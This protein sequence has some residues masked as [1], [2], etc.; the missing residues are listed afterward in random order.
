VYATNAEIT[1][2]IK[3]TGGGFGT[4]S[5][6]TI[7]NG[8]TIDATGIISSGTGRI[9]IG[10][11][12]FISNNATDLTISQVSNGANL[13]KTESVAGATD[14]P[15]RLLIGGSG[16]QV[17]VVQSAQI[18]GDSTVNSD[19]TSTA[20]TNAY[21]SGGLR[22]IFTSSSGNLSGSDSTIIYNYPSALTGDVL[23]VYDA[24][25]PPS[26]NFK[27]IVSMYIKTSGGAT[28]TTTTT[29]AATT[30][31]TAATTTTTAAPSV[32]YYQGNSVCNSA[33]GCYTTLPNVSGPFTASSI[34]SDTL[35][36]PSTDR[37]K[38]VYR[39]TS[40]DALADAAQAS[41]VDCATTTTTTAATTTTTAATT[42]TTA[43]T[44]TT[45][46][47]T[48]TTTAATTTTT[49]ATTTT[50]AAPCPPTSPTR[51]CTSANAAA[52]CCSGGIAGCGG[53][54]SISFD[55]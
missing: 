4:F 49:A 44:T 29:T 30:T 42:T 24:S 43:A 6:G 50:T 20:A 55:C 48:T 8:W 5:S 3:A 10:D 15:L 2:I 21:R 18:S 54:G 31:T 22:N 39:S 25:T 23:V 53:S 11:Y 33:S 38:N 17:E 32:T 27:K 9:K 12:S 19:G 37:V 26:G 36:G 7:T 1:G 34:P 13:I 45:T 28:T 41:C 35:T 14:S 40:G 16:R 52:N 47:A 46:A 51:I